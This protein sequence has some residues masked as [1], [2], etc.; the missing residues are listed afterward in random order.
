M[1]FSSQVTSESRECLVGVR[2]TGVDK[3]VDG[4]LN[5]RVPMAGQPRVLPLGM[6]SMECSH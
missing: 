6:Y 2:A 1:A 5:G 4:S 3:S